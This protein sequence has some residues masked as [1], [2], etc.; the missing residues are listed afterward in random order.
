MS[1]GDVCVCVCVTNKQH[2]FEV[3]SI[4]IYLFICLLKLFLRYVVTDLAF[5]AHSLVDIFNVCV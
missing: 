5:L 3:L 1:I 2:L 4:Y